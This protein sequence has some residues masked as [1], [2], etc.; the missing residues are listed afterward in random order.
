[1]RSAD[2]PSPVEE[3]PRILYQIVMDLLWYDR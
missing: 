2:N 3:R 1:L